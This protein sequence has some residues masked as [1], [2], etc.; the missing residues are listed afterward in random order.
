METRPV[1]A[2]PLVDPRPD[3]RRTLREHLREDRRRARRDGLGIAAAAAVLLVSFLLVRSGL[4]VDPPPA[5]ATQAAGL[6]APPADWQPIARPAALY[7][8]PAPE[9]RGLPLVHQARRHRD[10]GREDVLSF[11]AFSG[12]GLHLRLVVRSADPEAAAPS[13]F[14]DLVRRA[15][16]AG[17]AVTRSGAPSSVATKFGPAEAADVAIEEAVERDCLA[18]RSD[19]PDEAL[20]LS[21][22][23]CGTQGRP[24]DRQLLAC[25]LDRLSLR[26][27]Q[28]DLVVKAFFARAE[29]RRLPACAGRTSWLEAPVL[30]GSLGGDRP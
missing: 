12:D 23:V 2:A 14:I 21:G 30:R 13:F 10:G 15:A 20:R 1:S 17:F 3:W 24:A 9:L 26:P 19:H 11:G 16:E 22:W 18:F 8:L 25:L 29:E 7:Q 28:D 6:V 27:A 4:L 5:P